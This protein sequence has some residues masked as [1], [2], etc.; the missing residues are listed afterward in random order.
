[1]G[2]KLIKFFKKFFLVLKPLFLTRFIEVVRTIGMPLVCHWHMM[3]FSILRTHCQSFPNY[4]S[5]LGRVGCFL[6]YQGELLFVGMCL[7][8]G[9]I[10][11][12]ENVISEFVCFYAVGVGL[13]CACI[14]GISNS[15]VAL[16]QVQ[17]VLT[18]INFVEMLVL[19]QIRS[20]VR[21][22]V[23]AY[24]LVYITQ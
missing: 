18:N 1:M 4:C 22:Y 17:V 20:L 21:Y 16:F 15:A 5:Q 24:G 11:R 2:Y 3:S 6:V 8:M 19:D 12:L 13:R 7:Y 9:W 23:F 10:T 14:C